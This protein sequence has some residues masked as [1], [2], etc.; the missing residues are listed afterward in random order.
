MNKGIAILGVITLTIVG[1]LLLR[2]V[3]GGDEDTWICED[4]EWV[5][6]GKPSAVKP[7]MVCEEDKK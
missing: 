2:F 3:I 4:G 7:Q 1:L 6:H 5:K